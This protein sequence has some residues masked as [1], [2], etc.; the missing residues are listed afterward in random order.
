M[1]LIENVVIS[2]TK[3]KMKRAFNS[4]EVKEVS[5]EGLKEYRDVPYQSHDGKELLRKK[6]KTEVTSNCE[7]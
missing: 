1:G 2:A 6:E 3:I 7:S 5:S 4:G